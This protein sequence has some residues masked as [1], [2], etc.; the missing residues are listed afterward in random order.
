MSTKTEAKPIDSLQPVKKEFFTL[1]EAAEVLG[2]HEAT[3]RN[4]INLG[5]CPAVEIPCGKNRSRRIHVDTLLKIRTNLLRG[6][7]PTYDLAGGRSL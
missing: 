4:W 5:L 2:R 6:L 1:K 3:V 7:P